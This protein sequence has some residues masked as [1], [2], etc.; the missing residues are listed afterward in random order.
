MIQQ[1]HLLF[2]ALLIAIREVTEMPS[3]GYD[4]NDLWG[5]SLDYIMR[6]NNIFLF[7][8]DPF[9]FILS[10]IFRKQQIV[11]R[12]ANWYSPKARERE[13]ERK[14]KNAT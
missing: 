5:Q 1:V 13:P 2:L 11:G 4:M 7:N 3:P 8:C 9:R 10:L 14:H 12:Q 6:K